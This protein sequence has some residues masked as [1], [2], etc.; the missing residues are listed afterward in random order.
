[1]ADV[2]AVWLRFD[3]LGSCY[4][5]WLSQM[6]PVV[7]VESPLWRRF[8]T[9]WSSGIFVYSSSGARRDEILHAG[10]LTIKT[11]LL[12]DSERDG[13]GLDRASCGRS[14]DE[15]LADRGR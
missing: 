5:S 1:M 14:V 9:R 2:G 8:V 12:S 15:T 13:P 11:A 6:R 10:R 7:P 3:R 4:R